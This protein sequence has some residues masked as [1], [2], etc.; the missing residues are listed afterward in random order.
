MSLNHWR[1]MLAGNK[2]SYLSSIHTTQADTWSR[3]EANLI[4]HLGARGRWWLDLTPSHFTSRNRSCHPF[5]RMLVWSERFAEE[6]ILS[7]TETRTPELPPLNYLLPRRP[8]PFSS[9]NRSQMAAVPR[10]VSVHY[11]LTVQQCLYCVFRS[12]QV[13]SRLFRQKSS[14][15]G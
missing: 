2:N 9:W 13:L 15:L 12:S 3:T 1:L 10:S 14:A 5:D 8:V 4:L 11:F 7:N 6:N